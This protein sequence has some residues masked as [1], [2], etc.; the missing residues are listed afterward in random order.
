MPPAGGVT[1]RP[2]HMQAL[3]RCVVSQAVIVAATSMAFSFGVTT[4]VKTGHNN[5]FCQNV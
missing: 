2:F 4:K 3:L 5:K 1:P